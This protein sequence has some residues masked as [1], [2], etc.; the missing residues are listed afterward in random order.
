M[1]AVQVVAARVAAR[2]P[3]RKYLVL[4]VF[5]AWVLGWAV[6]RG[7][8]TLQLGEAELTPLHTSL[9][10]GMD[11]VDAGRNSNPFFLYFINYIRLFLD[12][13]VTFVQALI[14]QPSFGRPLPVLGWLGVVG[15]ATAVAY[16]YGNRRVALLTA[17]GFLS[18]GVLGLWQESMDTLA[19]TLTAVVLSL[20]VGIP[21]GVWAGLSDRFHRLVTPVLDFMQTMPTFV[22]LAPLTLFFLI[23]P[24]SATVATMVY[25][26]PPAIRI[27]A[28][29]IRQVSPETLEASA[30][31]GV[32]RAQALRHVRLPMAKQT[33]IVGVNQTI[34][35]ALS[36]ATIA[37][38]IDAPGLGKTVLKALQTLDVGTAFNAGLAIVIMAVVLDRATSAASRRVEA[39]RRAGRLRTVRGRRLEVAG[40][41]GVAAV[42]G[43]LSYTYVWAAEFPV[44]AN[45]GFTVR[46]A[47]DAASLWVQDSLVTYTDAVKNGL[48]NGLLN[49]FEALLTGSPWWLVAAVAVAI[50]LLVGSVRAA[51]VTTAGL[52]V[53]VLLGLWQDS[54]VTLASTLV[55]T[56]LV[57]V[58]GVIVGVWMGRSDRADTLLRPVLDAGQTMPAFV[59]LVP[60]LG[61]FGPTRFTA[62]IAAVVF[63]APIAI[64]LVAEGIRRVSA[65]TVE[66]ATSAGASTWQLISKVQ[67]PMARSAVTLSASQGLIYV[68]SMVV[69][70][71][72]VGA[73]ALGYDVVAGFSQHQLRGKGLAAGLAIV[74]L[75]IVLDRVMRAATE[76]ADAAAHGGLHDK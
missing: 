42:L 6:L 64:K 75:G 13:A 72:L 20:A 2:L 66:A 60:I 61:L 50:A 62:I 74:V 52:L 9:G 11:A 16:L 57:M 43:Y 44:Q 5:V 68:L 49:P 76:R 54:M 19:L 31:L 22:Y 45:L 39:E 56:I 33:I 36:M 53:L 40:V 12:E 29:G 30:S 51:L 73:G 18:F 4:A 41:L 14:S 63:A 48:T 59:Y 10:D 32:T 69:V 17:A 23:G 46:G 34:M 3:A 37:A 65:T 26:I 55:A 25:A 15:L 70:G 21:L 8:D 67:L 71:G 35:A 1:A 27:T 38:L 7:R 47:A 24:A 28:H 58:L